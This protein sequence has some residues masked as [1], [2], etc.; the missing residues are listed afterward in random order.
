MTTTYVDTL[1]LEYRTRGI[2]VDTNLLLL[3]FVGSLDL[4]R[5]ERFKRT[6]KYTIPDFHVLVQLLTYFGRVVI[7]PHI[8]TE[9][10]NLA[11]QLSEPLGADCHRAI[12]TRIA[13]MTEAYTASP[14]LCTTNLWNLSLPRRL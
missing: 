12:A 3:Y 14:A 8:L 4:N 2:L 6:R 9:V 7:T 13:S 5:I 11:G 10:S 1:L